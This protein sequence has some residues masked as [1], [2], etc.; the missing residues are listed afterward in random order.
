ML[1]VFYD[2]GLIHTKGGKWNRT[3]PLKFLN[4]SERTA[5]YDSSAFVLPRLS[6]LLFEGKALFY[7]LF[8]E[9]LIRNYILLLFFLK[10]DKTFY[11]NLYVFQKSGLVKM[12]RMEN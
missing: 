9:L 7:S 11:P 3:R 2:S 8:K 4:E 10:T 6:T 5:V 1:T 12:T